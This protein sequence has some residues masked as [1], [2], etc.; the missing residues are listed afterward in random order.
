M[1]A[2]MLGISL[3]DMAAIRNVFRF[4]TVLEGIVHVVLYA[5]LGKLLL[6]AEQIFG[7]TSLGFIVLSVIVTMLCRHHY[8]FE[9]MLWFH[10]VS[11]C[12]AAVTLWRHLSLRPFE[13]EYYI[14]GGMCAAAS[15]L[16]SQLAIDCYYNISL[17]QKHWLPL[18]TV[19]KTYRT[20][21]D[22]LIEMRGAVSVVIHMTCHWT[23]RPGQYVYVTVPALGSRYLF[24]QHPFWIA[25]WR[26]DADR[27]FL[28]LDLL[29]KE[30]RDFTSRLSNDEAR[31][32]WVSG[33]FGRP[34]PFGEYG[35]VLM[36]ATDIGIAAH[37]PYLKSLKE[38]WAQARVRTRRIVLVWEMSNLNHDKWIKKWLDEIMSS[39]L[40]KILEIHLHGP[41]SEGYD[42]TDGSNP[43]TI[44][45]RMGGGLHAGTH[46]RVHLMAQNVDFGRIYREEMIRPGRGKMVVTD[47]A[48]RA[49]LREIVTLEMDPDVR[50]HEHEFQPS[51][52]KKST[53]MA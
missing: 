43:R 36:F 8:F 47:D 20:D 4:G 15:M 22:D 24:Q 37:L 10:F 32:V 21:S 28:R 39:D 44:A 29:I 13:S 1:A 6:T 7:I 23:I 45:V 34:Q 40:D 19:S 46:N 9:A 52:A 2:D 27:R 31:V 35:T 33:P 3:R 50:Y 17:R 5:R 30:R 25:S 53:Y 42:V 38:S 12:G 49:T 11:M 16:L 51:R 18:I 41:P 14:L 48:S 26:Q